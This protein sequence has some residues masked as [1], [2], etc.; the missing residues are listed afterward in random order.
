METKKNML[1]T[2]IWSTL[3]YGCESWTLS[4]KLK[5]NIEAAEMWFYRRILKISYKDHITNEEVLRRVRDN[6]LLLSIITER[7]LRFLGYV[8]RRDGIENLVMTEKLNRKRSPG[9]QRTTFMD[10]WTSLMRKFKV[11]MKRFTLPDIV[12]NGNHCGINILSY[13][14]GYKK[15]Y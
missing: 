8:M 13:K 3:L 7:Q 11:Q 15:L 6:I 10:H 1:K 5:R 4:Q 9:R 12:K 14:A 2:Y